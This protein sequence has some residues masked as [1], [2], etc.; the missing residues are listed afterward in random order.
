MLTIVMII[1][2]VVLGVGG[3]LMFKYGT[4]KKFEIAILNGNFNVSFNWMIIVGLLSYAI[5]FILFMVLISKFNI[6][7]ITPI[8]IGLN[9]SAMLIGALIFLHEKISLPNLIGIAIIF[10]GVMIIALCG[11]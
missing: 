4:N 10:I 7:K 6:S 9:Y 2:Y 5:S 1:L 8:L 3:Q 11:N